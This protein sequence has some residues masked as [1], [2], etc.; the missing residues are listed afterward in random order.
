[1]SATN[2]QPSHP[3][4]DQFYSGLCTREE[5]LAALDR[6]QIRGAFGEDGSFTGYDY[7]N[8]DWI[9]ARA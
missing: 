6:V 2:P 8:Q 9:V 3:L 7:A 1:M 4:L 5:V